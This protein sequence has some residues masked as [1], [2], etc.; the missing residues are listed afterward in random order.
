MQKL[1]YILLILLPVSLM[2]QEVLNMADSLADKPIGLM[3][4]VAYAIS[5][6]QVHDSLSRLPNTRHLQQ[7]VDSL[8]QLASGVDT[9]Q[10]N[11]ALDSLQQLKL[12]IEVYQAKEDSIRRVLD[13]S[14]KL[15]QE[16]Q[17]LNQRLNKPILGSQE[18]L[19]KGIDKFTEKPEGMDQ[20]ALGDLQEQ[21][22]VSFST[23]LPP[24]EGLSLEGINLPSDGLPG[25]EGVSVGDINGTEIPELSLE[26]LQLPEIKGLEASGLTEGIGT[27]GD[28]SGELQKAGE[29]TEDIGS[30]SKGKLEEMKKVDQLA[31]QQLMNREETAFFKEQTAGAGQ[32]A[33]EFLK[34]R[35][36]DQLKEKAMEETPKAAIDHF[37]AHKDK[38]Q[39]AQ[40]K[41]NK[42]KGRYQEI[43][44]VKEIPKNPLKRNPLSGKPWPERWIIGSV[45][46]FH[47]VGQFK[48]DL[49]P[50]LAYRIS[51]KIEIGA[52][53][54]WRLTVDKEAP[55]FLSTRDWL[56]GYSLFADYRIKKGFFIRGSMAHLNLLPLEGQVSEE[57]Q[58]RIWVNSFALGAGK[59]YTFFKSF[60]GYSLIQYS[61]SEGIDKPLENPLQVKI[62]FYIN[63]KI[64]IK[65]DKKL[66]AAEP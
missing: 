15:D 30:L 47:K 3:D 5:G 50:S 48:I 20:E 14:A 34:Y 19:Q 52:A 61:F 36:V 51:D 28:L 57:K 66:T 1:L 12:P 27:V 38:L 42:H 45:W 26:K 4:S 7:K 35:N 13:Y 59:S 17:A 58:N 65:P 41:L 64:F 9:L 54:Q 10:L 44:S 6:V 62:G 8:Q 40:N 16:I 11:Q 37:S 56:S 32:P 39:A 25:L 33:E 63:G 49:G 53:Y 2:G 29:Y 60:K 31:E 55:V 46:Q 43:K 22:G 18:K 24:I 21:T 23:D